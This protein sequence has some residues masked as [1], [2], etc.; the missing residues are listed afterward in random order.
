MAAVPPLRQGLPSAQPDLKVLQQVWRAARGTSGTDA[1]QK[2]ARWRFRRQ[3]SRTASARSYRL[4]SPLAGAPGR[5]IGI[6]CG[7]GET[8][9][10]FAEHGGQAE[11]ID[12]DPSMEPLHREHGIM[13]RIGQIET[14]AL[15]GH[16]D[17]IHIAHAIY[18]I[19]QPM[20]L[21]R[22]AP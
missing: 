7:L 3:I 21:L 17:L 9:R 20:D 16:Y 6:A 11:G 4:F 13:S 19:R 18:F 5:F 14:I 1:D 15:Q 10:R 12:A 2:A 22:T 8:V